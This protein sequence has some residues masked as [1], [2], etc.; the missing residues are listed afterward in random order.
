MKDPQEMWFPFQ[1]AF[2]YYD[3]LKLQPC[4]ELATV[5]HSPVLHHV[6]C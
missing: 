2:K 4:D 6:Q 1:D 5:L 3:T